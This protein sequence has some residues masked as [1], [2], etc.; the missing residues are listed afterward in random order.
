MP[1]DNIDDSKVVEDVN[2]LPEITSIIENT[3]VNSATSTVEGV[4]VS[5]DSNSNDMNAIIESNIPAMPS[6]SFE[7][8]Y[9]DYGFM[10]VHAELIS[11][12]SSELLVMIQQ[13][14]SD[15]SSFTSCL[16]FV[17]KSHIP[18]LKGLNVCHPRHPIY[19]FFSSIGVM[20]R[21]PTVLHFP[22]T[23][24]D[25]ITRQLANCDKNYK[26]IANL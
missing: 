19:L 6:K 17:P 10:I 20:P 12:K 7:F 8:P 23:H 25:D 4:H 2:I 26:F 3:L 13:M 21:V 22:I 11:S 1:S 14:I 24:N 18:P 15:V 5:S 9:A 16:E